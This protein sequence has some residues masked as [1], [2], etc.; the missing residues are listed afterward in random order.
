[1]LQMRKNRKCEQKTWTWEKRH[2]KEK[3]A[4]SWNKERAIKGKK[5]EGR[6]TNAEE[7]SRKRGPQIC[8]E[9]GQNSQ[10]ISGLFL[11]VFYETRILTKF[12]GQV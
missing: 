9:A 7:W 5:F 11:L 1:M 3:K 10:L 2:I 8:T 12:V 4:E 6:N